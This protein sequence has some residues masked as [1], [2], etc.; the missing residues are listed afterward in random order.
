MLTTGERGCYD[1]TKL[2]ISRIKQQEGDTSQPYLPFRLNCPISNPYF[3]YEPT[4]QVSQ[5]VILQAKQLATN[6]DSTRDETE[7]RTPLTAIN[8]DETGITE[9]HSKVRILILTA[10]QHTNQPLMG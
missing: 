5:Q 6:T 1:R 3:T 7:T 2:S 9:F 8:T 4:R 10:T